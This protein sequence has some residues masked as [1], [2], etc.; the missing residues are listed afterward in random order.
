MAHQDPQ[1]PNLGES[2][3]LAQ[4]LVGQRVSV[5]QTTHDRAW[6]AFHH[7]TSGHMRLL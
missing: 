5:M 1:A 3:W 4:T 7:T 2:V 6:P